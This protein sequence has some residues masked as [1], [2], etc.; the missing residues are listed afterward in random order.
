MNKLYIL[1]YNAHQAVLAITDFPMW[2]KSYFMSGSR[3][4][5]SIIIHRVPIPLSHTTP[6]V[7]LSVD[8]ATLVGVAACR[9]SVPCGKWQWGAGLG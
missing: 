3:R 6:P 5:V 7:D 2:R 4:A 1:G 8:N 9:M